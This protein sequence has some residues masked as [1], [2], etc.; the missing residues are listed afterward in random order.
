M[1]VQAAAVAEDD[2]GGE[3]NICPKEAADS[4]RYL[5]QDDGDLA[6][7]KRW[8][9][10][11]IDDGLNSSNDFPTRPYVLFPTQ[12]SFVVVAEAIGDA[13]VV[14][15]MAPHLLFCDFDMGDVRPGYGK[16]GKD[17]TS[18]AGFEEMQTIVINDDAP[19]QP[20]VS[21]IAM[22]VVRDLK[23]VKETDDDGDSNGSLREIG[24]V[25]NETRPAEGQREDGQ[26]QIAAAQPDNIILRFVPDVVNVGR[27][28]GRDGRRPTVQ[29]AGGDNS[30]GKEGF[31]IAP[32]AEVAVGQRF[33]IARDDA[34]AVIARTNTIER[35]PA[36]LVLNA[37]VTVI[38]GQPLRVA[39]NG[40][41]MQVLPPA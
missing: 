20:A 24:P 2:H 25:L 34:Q 17:A 14:E 11:M 9:R 6:G 32:E 39:D 4:G 5:G 1:Q 18:V 27:G 35:L 26:Q 40:G 36:P 13:Q 38:N 37:L 22:V 7:G 19:T 3:Q 10:A 30:N 8:Q 28:R 41:R 29:V 31:H 33:V 15:G 23:Q 21:V 12:R 16:R